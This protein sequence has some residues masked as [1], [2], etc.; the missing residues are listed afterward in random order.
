MGDAA[1][2]GD[3]AEHATSVVALKHEQSDKAEQL[4]QADTEAAK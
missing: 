2:S 3:R 4:E 1:G